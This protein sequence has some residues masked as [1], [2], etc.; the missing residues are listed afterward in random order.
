M[1]FVCTIPS[2]RGRHSELFSE[3]PK[4]H[5]SLTDVKCSQITAVPSG[6]LFKV[7]YGLRYIAF[8]PANLGITVCVLWL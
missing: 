2:A 1:F 3:A 4:Q 8:A 5:L 7:I 6:S